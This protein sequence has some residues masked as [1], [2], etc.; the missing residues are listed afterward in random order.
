MKWVL[1]QLAKDFY[2]MQAAMRITVKFDCTFVCSMQWAAGGKWGVAVKVE[3][4]KTW[5]LGDIRF[6]HF[7]GMQFARV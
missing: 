5:N 7:A 4:Q 1:A 3:R 6:L 2:N